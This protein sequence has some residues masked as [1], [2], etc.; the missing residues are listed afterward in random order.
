MRS[1][2]LVDLRKSAWRTKERVLIVVIVET[3]ELMLSKSWWDLDRKI[4]FD[5]IIVTKV[6]QSELCMSEGMTFSI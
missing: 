4:R 2:S 3:I 5:A 6:V 1:S